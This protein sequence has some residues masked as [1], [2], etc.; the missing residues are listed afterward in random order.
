MSEKPKALGAAG[1]AVG[2][3]AL[4]LAFGACCVAPGAVALLGVGGAVMLARLAVLQPY[5][6]AATLALCGLAFSYAYRK[7]PAAAALE[8]CAAGNG[9]GLRV[10]VWSG[11][12]IVVIIDVAS[13]V[14]RLSSFW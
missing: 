13:Y 12:L 2:L 4:A 9:R 8:S 14:P 1:G 11:A 7:R 10:V 6:V 3:N 5:V